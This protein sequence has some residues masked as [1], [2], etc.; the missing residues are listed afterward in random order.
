MKRLSDYILEYRDTIGELPFDLELFNNF[1]QDAIIDSNYDDSPFWERMK[2]TVINT[3]GNKVWRWFYGYCEKYLEIMNQ[4]DIRDFYDSLKQTPLNRLERVLGAG[5]NGIVID[6]GD[7]IM[8]IYYGEHIKNTDEPFIKW[9][10]HNISKVFPK[11]YKVG[12]NWC[13]MEK[14]KTHTPKC[15]CYMD[16]I[17]GNGPYNYINDISKGRRLKDTSILSQEQ[18]E[19]YNWCWEVKNTMDLINSKCIKYPGD[20]VLNNIG[21]RDNGEIVFF[22]V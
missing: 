5:S 20:L 15:K 14:L 6:Q 22:D 10:Y 16:I 13:T 18:L 17:D 19:V 1:M 4:V 21:E 9:C 2:S 3:Y 11:V 12:K 7:R 8:K